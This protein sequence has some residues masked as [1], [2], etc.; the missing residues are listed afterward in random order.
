[1]PRT[2]VS[3]KIVNPRDRRHKLLRRRAFG[4]AEILEGKRMQNQ[5]FMCDTKTLEAGP[6]VV[7]VRTSG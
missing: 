3:S 2:R 7:A 6:R 1:M 5:A 4:S